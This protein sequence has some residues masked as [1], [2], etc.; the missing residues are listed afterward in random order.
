[1]ALFFSRNGERRLEIEVNEASHATKKLPKKKLISKIET[2]VEMKT[3]G[4]S[5]HTRSKGTFILFA[6]THN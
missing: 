4:P 1:M 2:K 5:Y 6:V 3:K